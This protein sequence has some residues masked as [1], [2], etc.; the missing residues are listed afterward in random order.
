MVQSKR[1]LIFAQIGILLLGI[2]GSI[3]AAMTPANSMMNWYSTDDAFFYF[4]VARNIVEGH[5]STF[6]GINLT[7]GYHPLWMLVCMAVFWLSRFH[8]LLP[9]RVLILVS[10]LLN[11]LSGIILFR[12]L[13]RHLHLFASILGALVWMLLPV[14]Y[15]NYTAKGLETPLSSL[16]I[17]LFL[18]KGVTMLESGVVPKVLDY[19]LLGFLASITVLSRLDNVFL[20]TVIGVF[21]V[22]RIRKI[23]RLVIFDMVAVLLSSVLSWIFRFS[24]D[25]MLLNNYSIYPI[26]LTSLTIIPIVLYATGFYT[27]RVNKIDKHFFL[28]LGLAAALSTGLVYGAQMLLRGIGFKLLISRSLI[29]MVVGISIVVVLLIRLLLKIRTDNEVRQPWQEFRTWVTTK[30]LLILRNGVLF[31]IP[32]AV[33]VGGYMVFN[34]KMFGTASPVSGQVKHW[35]GTLVETVYKKSDSL[36]SLLGLTP[37]SGNS[38][39]SLIT[40]IIADISIFLRN[41]FGENSNYLP[42]YL[43]LALIFIFFILMVFLLSRKDGYLA[44]KSFSLLIPALVLGCFIQIAYYS[45]SGYG[46]S[47]S[48][49]WV[50]ESFTLVIL[51]AV[52]S[53][54]F[55]EKVSQVYK[56]QWPGYFF[57]LLAAGSVFF[58]HTR[59]LLRQHPYSIPVD[60][61]IEYL[62]QV[63]A[64]EKD[65]T[66]GALIGMTGGGETAYFIQYRTIV[67][68]DG[69]INSVEYFEALKSGHA[70]EFLDEM[71]LDYVFGNPYMLLESNPYRSIFT[72]RLKELNSIAGPDNFILFDYLINR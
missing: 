21:V 61:E 12:L 41:L 72:G 34:H 40:T 43:F 68:L 57:L 27:T 64:L 70:D 19:L 58:L 51:G 44:R 37:G 9:L 42:L 23:R 67:N 59:Y 62:A 48:W 7:N 18:Y 5:G 32:I 2:S 20:V 14:I 26:M 6:D 56:R 71:E 49:Y 11:G 10:G 8:I 33:L 24:S 17:I 60:K 54:K 52:F 69:L 66:E 29:L 39:W 4:Q 16:M 28:Y 25:P 30:F 15:D 38:P 35:W 65:T 55:F 3:Y 63:K 50:S 31:S 45:A 13:R 46:H 53:S 22:F 1:A 36:V 47:R